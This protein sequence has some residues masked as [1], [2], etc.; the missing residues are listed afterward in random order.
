M[1]L[2][3][4]IQIHVHYLEFL[5][6]RQVDNVLEAGVVGIYKC[7]G[8]WLVWLASDSKGNER[9]NGKENQTHCILAD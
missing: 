3:I 6:H 4:Y 2:Y 1:A 8:L 7:Q 9:R 5:G